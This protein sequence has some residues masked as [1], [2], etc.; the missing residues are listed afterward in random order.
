LHQFKAIKIFFLEENIQLN[1]AQAGKSFE[2]CK[3]A[4]TS[5]LAGWLAR[6]NQ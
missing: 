1:R 2:K 5:L 3:G 4:D 6:T